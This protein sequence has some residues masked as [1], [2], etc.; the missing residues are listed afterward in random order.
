M[1]ETAKKGE[2]PGG[3]TANRRTVDLML[4]AMTTLLFLSFLWL[5]ID[6]PGAFSAEAVIAGGF[7]LIGYAVASTWLYQRW[8]DA[9]E[10]RRR[11]S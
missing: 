11:G 9:D 5:V 6:R 3:T 10:D 2:A 1:T 8:I 7:A 4:T